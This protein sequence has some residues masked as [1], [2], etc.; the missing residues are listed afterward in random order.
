MPVIYFKKIYREDLINNPDVLFLFGDN[1][2]RKGYGGQATEMRGEEN[3]IGIRTKWEPSTAKKAY[4]SDDDYE[5]IVDMIDDDL[6]PVIEALENDQIVV[7][8]VDGI[9]TGL[10]LLE[11]KAPMVYE[12]LQE[13]ME[14]LRDYGVDD[15]F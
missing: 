7:V 2:L 3:A 15:T 11:E 10:A 9:G 13:K 8:P 6:E 14:S 4:F 5:T 12:Y 1:D